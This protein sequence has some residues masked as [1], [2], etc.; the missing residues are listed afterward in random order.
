MYQRYAERGELL[1]DA[2]LVHA[3]R[4][5]ATDPSRYL[6][7]ADGRR[8]G[9]V[10]DARS[11]MNGHV[12][13]LRLA[14]LHEEEDDDGEGHRL[15]KKDRPVTIGFAEMRCNNPVRK[16]LSAVDLTA[17]LAEL[18]AVDRHMLELRAAGYTL[19]EI[20]DKVGVPLT[21]VFYNCRRLGL[22]L[23]E[24]AGI[25][26]DPRTHKPHNPEKQPGSTRRVRAAAGVSATRRGAP[27]K[28]SH[29]R[30]SEAVPCAA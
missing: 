7:R 13:V 6:A 24:R 12:E 17:W 15:E 11:F 10:F 5:K 2:I 22:A 8:K 25:P 20:G 29:T 26:I 27:R 4:L 1:D 14:D 19:E 23:A 16:I 9:D 30:R 21:A 3:C 18:P 28:A